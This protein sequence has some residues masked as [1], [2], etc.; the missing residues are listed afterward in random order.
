[1]RRRSTVAAIDV[2][3]TKVAVIVGDVGEHGETRILGVGVA[4]AAG[5][6]RGVIDNIQSAREAVRIAVE[7]AEQAC[8]M[9][10]LS[11]VVG[12]SGNHLAS[13]NNRGIIAIPDRSRPI[14]ADDRARVLEAA[15]QIS[16]PTN[17][18]VLH[19]LP[20]G[21][22]VEGTDPV[23]D[24]VG[25]FGGR[26][27]AE[28]HIVS[29]AV[30]AI[31]N[32]T[33]CV[34]GAGVQVD[35]I[36]LESIASA[37]SVI[38]DQER[39]QG[40]ALVDI[41]GS[42]TSLAVFDEGAVAHT[43]CLP[44]AGSHLTHDLARVLRCPWESAE[45]VKCQ[46]GAAYADPEMAR[47]N[48]EIHAFGTQTQK[49]VPLSHVCEILQ[50][51]SEEILEMIAGELKRAGYLDRL[52]AGLVLTGGSSQLRGLAEMAEMRLGIPAR[53]GKPHGYSGLSDIIGTPAYA[54]S[55]G[56]VEYA[57]GDRARTAEPVSAGFEVPVG[58]F[59]RRIASLGRALMPQ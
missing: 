16:I 48:I 12:I 9:R 15:G 20:R 53:I 2:G 17:R 4:P 30:S 24:P 57:L 10:I 35:D 33:K 59:F 28:T 47:E 19:V 22:W 34:E 42:T 54:T 5:L 51:R 32:L 43:A 55:I 7:K 46:Y 36:V 40:V 29:G 23:S 56:L 50:A 44:I 27:D 49:S 14:S 38:Q 41:G 39:L 45:E 1:M 25:M 31:Q 8:G 3:S 52:A 11:G 58:G 26:L 37:T 18:Q 6:T 13:Q 21:Y